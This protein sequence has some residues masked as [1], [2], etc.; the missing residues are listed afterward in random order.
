MQETTL[1]DYR[2]FCT[3]HLNCE[4]CPL[5]GDEVTGIYEHCMGFIS[6]YPEKADNIIRE[7]KAAEE[8]R[9]IDK[10]QTANGV[11]YL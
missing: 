6:E 1:K 9:K 11:C 3:E 7:W 5:C 8:K 10:R 4:S 2:E